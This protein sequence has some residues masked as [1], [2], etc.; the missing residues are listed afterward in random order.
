M[1]NDTARCPKGLQAKS[2]ARNLPERGGETKRA[3]VAQCVCRIS[4]KTGIL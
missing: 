4:R 3:K 2:S 1:P